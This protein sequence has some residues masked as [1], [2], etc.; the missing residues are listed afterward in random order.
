MDPLT[1]FV[2]VDLNP[3]ATEDAHRQAVNDGFIDDQFAPLDLRSGPQAMA[4]MLGPIADENPE[5]APTAEEIA[6]ADG[7]EL[8]PALA[9][10][11]PVAS[12]PVPPV[13]PQ[14]EVFQYEDGS[15]VTVEKT[16]KGWCAMLVSGTKNERFYGRTKDELLT[17]VLAAKLHATRKIN[18]LSRKLKLTARSE[19]PAPQP[20]VQPQL[21]DLTADEIFE[22]KNLLSTNPALAFNQMFQKQTGMSLN[23]LVGLLE[24]GRHAKDELD[25]EA[26][27]KAFVA[28]NPDY[29][30]D[31]KWENYNAIVGYL[32]KNKLNK[33][34]TETNQNEIMRD[35]IRGGQWTV[36][37]LQNAFEELSE[38]GLL[39][40]DPNASPDQEE[41]EVPVIV[42]PAVPAP[43]PP[44]VPAAAPVTPPPPPDPRIAGRRVAQRVGLGIRASQ[45]TTVPQE[46]ATR[47]PSADELD[48][49]SDT[50]LQNLFS[51]VRR[52]AAQSA[53]R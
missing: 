42:P 27:A 8:P 52:H 19:A 32:S 33:T 20:Q 7:T 53:R 2:A 22:I 37:N 9:S 46:A 10:P 36:E 39:L 38:D 23:Q 1:Q 43:A 49:L 13:A 45:T 44:A 5:F 3:A 21:R 6:A 41:E 16:S 48:N 50:E 31:P 47:P 30:A 12:P 14:P 40:T 15:T 28:Q 11:A 4:E 24:Q 17:N 51:G 18:E 25:S 29:Y 35:L 26:T 34:L